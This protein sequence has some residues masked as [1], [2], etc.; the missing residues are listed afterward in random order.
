MSMVWA[1]DQ[2]TPLIL[3]SHGFLLQI[4]STAG[5][6]LPLQK[7][8]SWCPTGVLVLQTST[9]FSSKREV[10][11]RSAAIQALHVFQPENVKTP[12]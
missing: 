1:A 4:E 12:K 5:F 7:A 10:R 8:A 6:R 3:S 11:H 9:Q 2:E